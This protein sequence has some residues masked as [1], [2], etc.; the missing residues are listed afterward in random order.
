MSKDQ[1][2]YCGECPN[3]QVCHERAVQGRLIKCI[4]NDND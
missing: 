3:Y 1:I 2:E 4:A